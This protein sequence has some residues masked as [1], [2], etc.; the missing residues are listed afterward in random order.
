MQLILYFRV[1]LKNKLNTKNQLKIKLI[2]LK[3]MTV[4]KHY[5]N[6]FYAF[7]FYNKMDKIFIDKKEACLTKFSQFY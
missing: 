7:H 6:F 2:L 5:I 1:Q 3:C 4:K